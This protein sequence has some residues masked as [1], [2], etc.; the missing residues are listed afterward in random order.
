LRAPVHF[1]GSIIELRDP[2]M[3]VVIR[4]IATDKAILALANLKG[5]SPADAVRLAVEQQLTR[6]RARLSLADR[7]APLQQA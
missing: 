6:E 2:A 4:D 3:S 1:C 5:I 7:L